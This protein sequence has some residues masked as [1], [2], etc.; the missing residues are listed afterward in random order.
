MRPHTK[1]IMTLLQER[2]EWC[3]N[4]YLTEGPYS[5]EEYLGV[6]YSSYKNLLRR[7]GITNRARKEGAIPSFHKTRTLIE[8]VKAHREE[9][10]QKFIEDRKRLRVELNSSTSTF[11]RVLEAAGV[12]EEL[13]S[14]NEIKGRVKRT[15]SEVKSNMGYYLEKYHTQGISFFMKEFN[16]NESNAEKLLDR[17]G[18]YNLYLIRKPNLMLEERKRFCEK[19]NCTLLS[20]EWKG[21]RDDSGIIKYPVKC[22]RCGHIFDTNLS[23]NHVEKCPMC[24]KQQSGYSSKVELQ[25][26][27]FLTKRGYTVERNIRSQLRGRHEIDLFLREEKVAFEFNGDFWHC[28][29]P[30]GKDKFYHRRKTEEALSNG[31]RLYHFWPEHNSI[32]LI[33]SV[34]LSKLGN[35]PH[36]VGARKCTICE[37]KNYEFFDRNHLD[38]HSR[39]NYQ[40]SLIYNNKI[41]ASLLMRQHKEGWEIARFACE[42]GYRVIG[43]YKRLLSKAITEAKKRGYKTIVSYCNRDL[44]PVAESS[45]YAKMG[46]RFV[47]DTGPIMWYWNPKQFCLGGKEFPRGVIARQR[48]QKHILLRELGEQEGTEQ[49]IL[50]KNFKIRPVYNSGNFKYVLDL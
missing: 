3:Y 14:M 31:I 22:N 9:I 11:Y 30:N 20:E 32:G 35:E 4:K 33:K 18:L 10:K 25:I 38:G 39:G 19:N 5:L 47:G 23:H 44:T 1:R 46:F 34:I 8:Y 16:L 50:Y 21:V 37:G 6:P 7:A 17:T 29:S 2:L 13:K 26:Y 12:T 36:V 48:L 49:E 24:S 41:I 15:T 45:I 42:R 43:G 40:V 28:T 27:D